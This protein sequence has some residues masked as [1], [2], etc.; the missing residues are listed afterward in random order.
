MHNRGM[1]SHSDIVKAIGAADL[2]AL[3]G[4]ALPTV[5][6]WSQRNSIPAD[7]WLAL[8]EKGHCSAAELMAGAAK[9]KPA[10]EAA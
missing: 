10:Q 3:T 1:R 6:S 8:V 9:D 2:A 4:A 7:H 5:Y